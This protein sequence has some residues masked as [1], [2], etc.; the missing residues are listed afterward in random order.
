MIK[1]SQKYYDDMMMDLSKGCM[2]FGDFE[3]LNHFSR[4]KIVVELGTYHGLGAMILGARAKKV[5][6]I[7]NYKG[8]GEEINNEDYTTMM[9]FF[10]IFNPQVLTAWGCDNIKAAEYFANSSV[11]VVYVNAAH[12]AGAVSYDWEAWLPKLR[13]GG[14]MLFHDYS[15][16]HKGLMRFI[17]NIVMKDIRVEQVKFKTVGKT[18]MKIFKKV[19]N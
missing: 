14:H 13:T 9:N 15:K 4:D 1:K 6:T 8:D 5:H 2:L 17:D 7:D 10:Q 18:V 19:C 16:V 3:I 12:D 11:D